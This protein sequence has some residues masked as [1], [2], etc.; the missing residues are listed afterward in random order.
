MFERIGLSSEGI[1]T[2]A[3]YLL[4]FEGGWREKL[5]VAQFS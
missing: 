1:T 3:S 5:A 2:A 4:Q